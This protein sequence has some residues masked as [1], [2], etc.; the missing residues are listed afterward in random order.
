MDEAAAKT[1]EV[2]LDINGCWESRIIYC[3]T[4]K[5]RERRDLQR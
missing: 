2:D 1:G 5:G 4:M 3:S